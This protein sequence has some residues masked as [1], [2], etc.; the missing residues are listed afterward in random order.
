MGRLS[1][2]NPSTKELRRKCQ[3]CPNTQESIEHLLWECALAQKIWHQLLQKSSGIKTPR[4][5]LIKIYFSAYHQR[6]QY[7]IDM[8]HYWIK[9]STWKISWRRGTRHGVY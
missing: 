7:G 2:F 6:S 3:L 5:Q 8:L 1:F 9:V 4:C